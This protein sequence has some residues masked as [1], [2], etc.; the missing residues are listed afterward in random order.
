MYHSVQFGNLFAGLY[1]YKLV[2]NHSKHFIFVQKCV[3]LGIFR[4][5]TILEVIFLRFTIFYRGF[6]ANL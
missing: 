4:K 5:S 3:G 2:L 1:D 6:Y